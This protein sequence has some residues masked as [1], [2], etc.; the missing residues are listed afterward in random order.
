MFKDRLYQRIAVDTSI[1]YIQNG[2][3]NG[4]IVAATGTGKSIIIA[5]LIE[6][7]KK[8]N[9][10][11]ILVCTH[12]AELI[13]QNANKLRAI[14]PDAK[15]G[16]YSAGLGE[17]NIEQITFAG[18]QSIYKSAHKLPKIHVLLIDEAHTI[19]RK[20]QS[21]WSTLINALRASN[22]NIKIFGL[23]AT[24]FRLDSGNLT[25]GENALFS[26][27]IYEYGMA[28]AIQDGYLVGLTAKHTE[29]VYNIDGVGKIGGEFNLKE[30][31]EATNI[32]ELTRK[33]VAETIKRCAGRKKWLVFCNGVEH[34][35]AVR[36]EFR[37]NGITCETVT[38]DTPDIERADILER[39]KRGDI[40]A[41]T[42]N[43]VWTTGIDV[44]DIDAIIM[45]RHTLSGG[46]LVQMAGRGTRVAINVEEYT[47]AEER[48]KAIKSSSKPNCLFLD[49]AGNIERHGFIDQIKGKNKKKGDGEA[50]V[51]FCPECFSICHAAA[52][53]CPD[54][55]YE[56]PVESKVKLDDAYGGAVLSNGQKAEWK[57]VQNIDYIPHNMH[58]DGKTPCLRV[59]YT[60]DDGSSISEYICIMHDGFAKQKADVWWRKMGGSDYSM[61]GLD[62]I[63]SDVCKGLKKPSR[64]LTQKDG[65]FDRVLD[66]EFNE[67]TFTQYAD[68]RTA[69][70]WFDIPFM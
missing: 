16:L 47:S 28:Q 37:R 13:E 15:I 56:F 33:A 12:V 59:K 53:K 69:S 21:M 39:F 57:E 42:N 35:F 30:L 8:A 36:D 34:S 17:K 43:A 27:I 25:D 68:P 11:N 63:A 40:Q 2:G 31:Q 18:I 1:K 19:S 46:L 20:D 67:Q 60:L 49:F 32:D 29:T 10:I 9:D 44:P 41:V 4:L 51:K 24:P 54:C 66:Y 61:F 7:L 23:S 64:I 5:R 38:G 50:P 52:S 62:L 26:D 14:M 6:R 65:K 55:G 3:S 58:K 45:L 48:R 70:T 22:P